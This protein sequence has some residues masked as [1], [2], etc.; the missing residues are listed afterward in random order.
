MRRLMI[1][2][3]TLTWCLTLAFG[4]FAQGKVNMAIFVPGV[5][6]GS[7]LYEQMVSGAQMVA[8]ENPGLSL[9][10]IEGGFNQ[11]EWGEKVM[12]LAATESYQY[13]LTSNP[14]MPFVCL[15]VAKAFPK[16]KFI[17]LDAYLKGNPQFYTALYNQV[18]QAYLCGYL[19]GLVTKS[20]MKGANADLKV[21]MI[22]AQEY[23]ALL[24]MMKPG[25]E[26]GLKA[27]DPGITVDYRVI[28]NWYDANKAGDLAK[29]MM[30]SG[31]DVILTIAGGANQG[32]IKAAQARGKY[33]LYFDSNE[34]K[35]AP[36]TII[37]CGI[38]RQEKAVYEVV[39]KALAGTLSF[40]A[41]DIL[42][43]RDGYVDFV[44][45]D[46]LYLSTIPQ[47]LRDR[48]ATVVKSI[49]TGAL[50]LEVPQL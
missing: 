27:V 43:A 36:G 42:N 2:V 14:S 41:A 16:Q 15:D 19:G 37:G 22:V 44:D 34:Y 17:N 47:D 33:V 29:S 24:K 25:Y 6:A 8:K 46:P 31:V 26:Q 40:G 7:P 23:P 3:L 11:A 18:E 38:L 35:L 32:V 45:N 39:K 5:V 30:D 9:K 20:K 50:K 4:A 13:I 12:S 21:G 10:V 49:R 48:M 28:G 1:G